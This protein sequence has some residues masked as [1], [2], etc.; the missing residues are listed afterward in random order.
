MNV[1]KS[2]KKE[3]FTLSEVLLVVTLTVILLAF[4]SSPLVSFYRSVV[5]QSATENVLA[6]FDEARKSTL[7]SL[8]SSQYGVH[9][10][11]TS[12]TLF[13]GGTYLAGDPDN[14]VYELNTMI[15]ITSISLSGGGNDVVFERITGETSQSGTL[16][17]SPKNGSTTPR[18]ITIHMSGLVEADQ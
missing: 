17:I 2:N 16:T 11:S 4:I 18:D 10:T 8:D 12:T 14:D 6:M 3:G 9:I 1:C 5:M 15:E 13:K 7:S